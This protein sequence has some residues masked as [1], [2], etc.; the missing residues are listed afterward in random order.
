M[1]REF[2][3]HLVHFLFGLLHH[4]GVADVADDVVDELD[5]GGH[6]QP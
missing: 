6:A 1:H 5:D 2:V 3:H 4:V